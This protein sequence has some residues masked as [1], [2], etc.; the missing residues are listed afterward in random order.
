MINIIDAQAAIIRRKDDTTFSPSFFDDFL[1]EHPIDA[2]RDGDIGTQRDIMIGYN[3][4][5]GSVFMFFANATKYAA[6]GE[7]ARPTT[8]ITLVDVQQFATRFMRSQNEA[9]TKNLLGTLY[10]DVNETIPDSVFNATRINVGEFFVAC[11]SM[12]MAE[13]LSNNNRSVYFYHFNH[14]PSNTPWASWVG[15]AHYE[16]VQ[17]VFGIP[18]MKPH[19]FTKDELLLSKQMMRSWATFAATGKPDQR[20]GMMWPTYHEREPWYVDI[21][22]KERAV[23]SGLP[24]KRCNFWRLVYEVTHSQ[25]ERPTPTPLFE[26]D[27]EFS[28]TR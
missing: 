26:E 18:L 15:A 2:L 24:Q 22:A 17:F 5:E 4:D 20:P 16:E 7:D 21:T 11:P 1:P 13:E 3:R 8:N 19:E 10:S 12:F 25:L 6:L 9:T 14:R 23:K 27:D 28:D